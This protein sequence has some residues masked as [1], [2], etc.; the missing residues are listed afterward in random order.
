MTVDSSLKGRAV[1][2]LL[3]ALALLVAGL[4][5]AASAHA[6]GVTTQSGS[7]SISGRMVVPPDLDLEKVEV[8]VGAVEWYRYPEWDA[9]GWYHTVKTARVAPDGTFSI[10]GL[11]HKEY[12][13]EVYKWSYRDDYLGGWYGGPGMDITRDPEDGAPVY[14]GA[15]NLEFSMYK[16]VPISGVIKLSDTVT[17]STAKVRLAVYDTSDR[18]RT[19]HG[20]I[21]NWPWSLSG[22]TQLLDVTAEGVEF[23][24][25]R[26]RRD[27]TLIV[28]VRPEDASLPWGYFHANVNGVVA[29]YNHATVLTAGDHVDVT[30]GHSFATPELSPFVV[31]R[32]TGEAVVGEKLTL[33]PGRW[34]LPD[35]TV[36]R[37][38]WL[39]D[40]QW[41]RGVTG[42]EYTLHE[43]DL[44]ATITVRVTVALSGY[45]TKAFDY[46]TS[47]PVREW[48]PELP[49]PEVPTPEDPTPEDPNPEDPNP[50]DPTVD[51]TPPK[52]TVAPQLTGTARLGKTLR[53]TPGTWDNPDVKVSYQWVR[54]TKAIKGATKS[55]YKLKK[56]DVG[57]RV[58]VRVTASRE[59][60]DDGV[61]TSSA[62]KVAKVKTKVTVKAATVKV[63]QR[64]RVVVRVRTGPIAKPAGTV[65]VKLG[66]RTVRVKLK[67]KHRGKVTAR[68]PRLAKG[69]HRITVRYAPNAKTKKH[70]TK[71]KATKVALRVR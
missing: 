70:V 62:K 51:T 20:T 32:L 44:G 47:G 41:I 8:R 23:T 59:G 11:P 67:A 64:P 19:E 53:A 52:A 65:R 30:V 15:S 40:G 4:L 12:R 10:S 25:P 26:H 17:A 35:V 18:V 6:N 45:T 24:I 14:P 22:N 56:K 68:L 71:P 29:D 55:T 48:T 36:Q 57:K 2:A 21:S 3:A 60:H 28:A 46:S 63:G 50:E 1:T 66:S 31:P 38:R 58:A 33:E 27:A 34:S 43:A 49:D 39:R 16:G 54:G 42:D 61:S 69:K 37:H 7:D 9:P 5:P 13:L